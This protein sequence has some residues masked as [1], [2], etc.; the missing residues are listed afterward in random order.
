MCTAEL[1]PVKIPSSITHLIWTQCRSKGI[2][3]HFFHNKQQQA[4]TSTTL[5]TINLVTSLE[6]FPSRTNIR[7]L[8]WTA[9]VQTFTTGFCTILRRICYGQLPTWSVER[10]ALLQVLSEGRLLSGHLVPATWL[11]WISHA[12]YANLQAQ[13]L[14]KGSPKGHHQFKRRVRLICL[15]KASQKFKLAQRAKKLSQNFDFN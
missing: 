2:I 8:S 4:P 11:K 10:I 14:D 13:T 3:P 15:I 7:L 9:V 5:W 6:T 1:S 12:T